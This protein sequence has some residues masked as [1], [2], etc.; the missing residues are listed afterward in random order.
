MRA[1]RQLSFGEPMELCDVPAPEPGPAETLVTVSRAAVNPLD[2][3]TSRGTA[4]GTLPRT[5]GIEGAGTTGDGRHVFFRGAGLGIVRDGSYAEQV[6][7]P[8]AVI[9]P[10]PDG[11]SDRDAAGIGV[12]GVTALDVLDMGGVAAEHRVLVLGA[13]GGVGSFACQL[14]RARG[15][16]VIAQTGNPANAP[17]LDGLADEVVVTD[18]AGLEEAVG[19]KVDV[20]LDPLSG[21]FTA[22]AVRLLIPNGCVVVFGASAG[23]ELTVLSTQL[24]RNRGRLLGYGQAGE[25]PADLARKTAHL[26]D[27]V[28]RGELQPSIGAELPLAEANEAHRRILAREAGGRLLLV[29]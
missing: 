25:S 1:M 4:G 6:A 12:G 26:L 17:R 16:H 18:A 24:Y 22:P 28:A 7:V 21:P 23:P 5:L 10:I 29:P 14:A 19:E 8:D 20:V 3:W 13:S 27:A 11:V 15:A 2:I 9:T